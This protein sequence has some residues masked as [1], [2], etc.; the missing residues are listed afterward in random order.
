MDTCKTRHRGLVKQWICVD[1]TKLNSE[2]SRLTKGGYSIYKDLPVASFLGVPLITYRKTYYLIGGSKTNWLNHILAR[3]SS[4]YWAN[5][6]VTWYKRSFKFALNE[7]Y[8]CFRKQ[9]EGPEFVFPLQS[10]SL[11]FPST[12]QLILQYRGVSSEVEL[13]GETTLLLQWHSSIS[14]QIKEWRS[15]Q[16]LSA[17]FKNRMRFTQAGS[18]YNIRWSRTRQFLNPLSAKGW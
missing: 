12:N 17:L 6:I 5:R 18:K 3:I 14:A 11:S 4:I 2:T 15:K 16:R 9:E 7:Y 13:F 8:V 10:A 1:S